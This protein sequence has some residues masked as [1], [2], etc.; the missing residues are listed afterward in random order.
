MR[1]PEIVHFFWPFFRGGPE[2]KTDFGRNELGKGVQKRVENRVQNASFSVPFSKKSG[3]L[4]PDQKRNYT[5][6]VKKTIK[7]PI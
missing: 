7:K 2:K 1:N 3:F 4:A 6:K 5:K